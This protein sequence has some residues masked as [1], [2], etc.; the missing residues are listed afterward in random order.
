MSSPSKII[1]FISYSHDSEPHKAKV[2]ALADKLRDNGLDCRVDR[3]EASP[4]QGWPAWMMR[5][6][7]DA[8]FVLVVCSEVYRRRFEGDEAPGKGKGAK[9]EGTIITQ[10]IYDAESQNRRFIPVIMSS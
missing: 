8:S 4:P 5:Q 9:F 10:S 6:L 7:R 3:Y 1:C 2:L